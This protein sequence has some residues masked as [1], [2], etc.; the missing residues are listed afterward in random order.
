M[1]PSPRGRYGAVPYA[2][3]PESI[4]WAIAGASRNAAPRFLAALRDL[5]PHHDGTV[6]AWATAIHSHAA[7]RAQAFAEQNAIPHWHSDLEALLQRTSAHC[8]Y[9]ANHPRHHAETARA[10]LEAGKHVLC[11]PPL[12][13]SAD[14]AADLDRIAQARGLTLALHY[15]HRTDPALLA[16]RGWVAS[17]DLGDLAGGVV[18]NAL[19]L[20]ISQQSWRI[21]PAWGGA[22]LER[23]LRTVDAVRFLCGEPVARVSAAAGPA[24]LADPQA[25]PDL[26][27]GLV[28]LE[29]VHARLTLENSGAVFATHDSYLV[30]HAPPRI[31]LYGSAGA[32]TILPWNDREPSRLYHYRGGALDESPLARSAVNLWSL[33]IIAFQ[34]AVRTGGPPPA[35]A[36]DDQANLALC[37]ALLKS[38]RSR[39]EVVV[40]GPRRDRTFARQEH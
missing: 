22:L 27:T 28:A 13:L 38:I 8:V 34:A 9:V 14:E 33:S 18:R 2:I 16:L 32:A 37:H 36:S 35:T 11:E 15:Q 3:G 21:E 10:A 26:D 40:G 5:P 25:P 24:V 6:Q 29:D 20:P 30:P 31:D 1:D 4:A 39:T 12:A 7:Y 17:H 19:L 23:T